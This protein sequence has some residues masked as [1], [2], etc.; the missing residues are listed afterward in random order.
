MATNDGRNPADPRTPHAGRDPMVD[1]A[2]GPSTDPFGT[3]P[4]EIRPGE[5]TRGAG[6]DPA[7]ADPV[8]ARTDPTYPGAPAQESR[9]TRDDRM[10]RP[11]RSSSGAAWGWAIGAVV[12]IAA[13]LAF[14]LMDGYEASDVPVTGAIEQPAPAP[15]PIDPQADT[16]VA[17]AEPIEAQ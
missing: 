17:P 5:T 2:P 10:A 12:V 13:V 8:H 16:P 4:G 6:P 3:R 11:A 14:F 7:P 15:V 9:A 1:P